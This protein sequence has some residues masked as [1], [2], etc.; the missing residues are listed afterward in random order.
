MLE[1]H[2]HWF[3][4]ILILAVWSAGWALIGSGWREKGQDNAGKN[5]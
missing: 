4:L 2:I 3:H 1:F 5:A